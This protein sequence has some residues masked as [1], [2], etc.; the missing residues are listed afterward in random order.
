MFTLNGLI[1]F[2]MYRTCIGPL[3]SVFTSASYPNLLRL[4]AEKLLAA[5]HFV[6]FGVVEF[7]L[8]D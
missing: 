2:T 8:V 1:S 6:R 3:L 5:D 4:F 7:A